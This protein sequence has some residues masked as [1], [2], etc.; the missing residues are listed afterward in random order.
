MD[1]VRLLHAL[2]LLGGEPHARVPALS[3]RQNW[4][5]AVLELAADSWC[6]GAVHQGGRSDDFAHRSSVG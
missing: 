1:G 3:G 6:R 2:G 5:P 4:L